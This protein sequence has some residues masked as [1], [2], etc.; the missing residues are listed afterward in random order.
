MIV[1]IRPEDFKQVAEHRPGETISATVEAVEPIGNETYV[2]VAA[3]NVTLTA[4]VG[5]R[6]VIKPHSTLNLV[7]IFENMHLFDIRSEQSIIGN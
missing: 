2:N 5:R 3:G 4:A 6:A 7:P 1:G